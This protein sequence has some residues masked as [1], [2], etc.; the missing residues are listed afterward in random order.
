LTNVA[1]KLL[2]HFFIKLNIFMIKYIKDSIREL[3][4]VVW[5]TR[6]ETT[7]YFVIVV[8]VLVLFGIYLFIASTLFTKGLFGLKEVVDNNKSL[9]EVV[10]PEGISSELKVISDESGIKKVEL[11]DNST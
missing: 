5:P 8:I 10:I 9:S 7:N 6:T 4:H 11:N 1:K 2:Q 3:K